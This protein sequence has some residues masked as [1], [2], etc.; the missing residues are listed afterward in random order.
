[1]QYRLAGGSGEL[2]HYRLPRKLDPLKALNGRLTAIQN[3]KQTP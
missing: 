3:R 2:T 1:V